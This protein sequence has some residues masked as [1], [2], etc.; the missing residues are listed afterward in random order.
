MERKKVL[1][2]WDIVFFSF[3]AIFG[4]EAIA[5]SAAIGPSAIFWWLF[6]ICGFFLPFG[7]I[8]AELG[9]T[10]PDQGGIYG[11]I[12]RALG[13]R[14]AARTTWYYWISLP[15]WLPAIYVAIAEMLKH[16]FFP[17]MN[18]WTLISICIMFTWI[19]VGINICSLESS[20]WVPGIGSVA[21]LVVIIGVIVAAFVS[22][23]KNGHFATEI[24]MAT[25]MPDLNMAVTYIPTIIYHLFGFEL[26][27]GAAGE[28]K[29]P[30]RDV[31]KALILSAIIIALLYLITT[32]AIWVTVPVSE[33]NIAGGILQVFIV[34]F[35]N[36]E[37][38]IIIIIVF[39]LCILTTLYT[40]MVP[41]TLGQ[42]RTIAEAAINGELPEIFG[43]MTKKTMA[44]IGASIISGMISTIVVVIYGLI[45]GSATKLFWQII[46]FSCAVN[47][48]S[49][50][51]LF[52]VFIILRRKDKSIIRP[53]RIPGP[54][55]LAKA[56]AVMAETFIFVAV[57]IWIIQP[58]HDFMKSAL[59]IIMGILITIAA[60]EIVIARKAR[61]NPLT[62]SHSTQK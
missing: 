22:F 11:W 52:P 24:N 41:W 16:M 2:F 39:G 36:H 61:A 10:Y 21:Q 1:G 29:N 48:L 49:Y 13:G 37:A 26:V 38:G 56:L 32:F 62:D 58:G 35:G 3:C 23:L 8:I 6:C 33:I 42:N 46:S 15:L 47:M 7:L 12:K 9:S 34:A 60:G 54:D 53:Y 19:T 30:A 59:P 17:C 55:W 14:W 50:L 45:T 5:A 28:M 44:P 51:I 40:G 31:P 27:L 43:K 57:L 25:L 18:H 4:V 20:K